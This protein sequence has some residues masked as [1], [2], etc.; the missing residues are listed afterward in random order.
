MGH[1]AS[2]IHDHCSVLTGYGSIQQCVAKIYGHK[3]PGALT[4]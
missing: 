2:A 1:T 3:G 4:L